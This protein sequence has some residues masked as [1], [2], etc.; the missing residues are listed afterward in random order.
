MAFYG[1]TFYHFAVYHAK[2]KAM[3]GLE[4][5][6]VKV[7]VTV[8]FVVMGMGYVI[9]GAKFNPLSSY[10]LAIYSLSGVPLS[11]ATEAAI[12]KK[13]DDVV[14]KKKERKSSVEKK[15][16]APKVR[17]WWRPVVWVLRGFESLTHWVHVYCFVVR[18]SSW[19]RRHR[20][21]LLPSGRMRP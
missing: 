18:P 10:Y 5:D 12:F 16:K 19:E 11:P 20:P 13:D 14:E 1:A 2:T 21:A 8:F 15:E 6:V 7:I 17:A 3:L 4:T 9:F